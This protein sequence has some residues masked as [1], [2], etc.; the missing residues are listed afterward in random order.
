[1][2]ILTPRSWAAHVQWEAMIAQ[3]LR[4]RGAEVDFVTCGGG[5]EICDRANLWEAPPM[6]CRTCTRYVDASIDAH[7]FAATGHGRGLELAPI[8]PGPSSTSCS[9]AELRARRPTGACRW[10][11]WSTSRS[12]GS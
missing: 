1:M 12:S 2:T 8:R 4:L 3:A 10:A 9:F 11:S 6:P 5:L 7:G